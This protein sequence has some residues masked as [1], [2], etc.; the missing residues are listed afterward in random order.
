MTTNSSKSCAVRQ[1]RQVVKTTCRCQRAGSQPQ[2]VRSGAAE[3]A[4]STW[5]MQVEEDQGAGEREG[6]RARQHRSRHYLDSV[7]RETRPRTS[8]S[9]IFCTRRASSGGAPSLLSAASNL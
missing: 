8:H 5:N 2:P 4:T 1:P 6:E 9:S 3:L 7:Y